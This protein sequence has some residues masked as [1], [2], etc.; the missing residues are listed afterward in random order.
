MSENA[1]VFILVGV[2]GSNQGARAV[3]KALYDEE[4]LKII[5]AGNTLSAHAL[6]KILKQL[7]H[8]SVYM[9]IIAKNFETWNREAILECSAN[10]WKPDIQR[11]NVTAYHCYG[12]QGSRFII[13]H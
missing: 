10:I 5:Y 12:T 8:K 3:I 9:N 13:L 1:D 6:S 7:D 4:D 2:G 11:G